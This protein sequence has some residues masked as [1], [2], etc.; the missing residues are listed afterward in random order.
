LAHSGIIGRI[1]GKLA[2]VKVVTTVH[3]GY[4]CKTKLIYKLEEFLLPLSDR[5]IAISQCVKDYLIQKGI[6]KNRIEIIRNAI[7]LENQHITDPKFKPDSSPAK[8]GSIGR[9]IR[10]KGFATLIEGFSRIEGEAH[11]EIIGDGPERNHLAELITRLSLNRRVELLG[12]LPNNDVLEKLMSWDM[13][14]FSPTWEGFGLVV[15]EAMSSGKPVIATDVGGIPEIIQDGTTGILVP[16]ENPK[17]LADKIDELIN[18]PALRSRLGNAARKHVEENFT[19]KEM[20]EKT[21]KIYKKL[22]T[23]TN[24]DVTS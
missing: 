22:V 21:K 11:L 23:A 24:M 20:V 5:I 3:F 13:F 19:L 2:G 14:V 1:V 8:I 17:A 10:R 4:E 15:L 12:Q 9:L 7:A 18:N 16:P 6:D